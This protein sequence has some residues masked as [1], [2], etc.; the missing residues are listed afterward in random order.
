MTA[1]LDIVEKR[2]AKFN[3]ILGFAIPILLLALLSPVL[4]AAFNGAVAAMGIAVLYILSVTVIPVLNTK[5]ANWKYAELVKEA[6]EN[7]M[8]TLYYRLEQKEAAMKIIRAGVISSNAAWVTFIT[9]GQKALEACRTELEAE[10]WKTRIQAAKDK[11]DHNLHELS[12]REEGMKEYDYTVKRSEI[13]WSAVVAE[14]AANNGKDLFEGTPMDRLMERTSLR[15]IENNLNES[16]ARMQIETI[17]MSK[18]TKVNFSTKLPVAE[19][20]S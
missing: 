5:L 8:P 17:G 10:N 9:A 1:V 18:P 7:P 15:S 16:L 6:N 4:V 11:I 3:S 12:I 14:R 19:R 2:K 13:E 20:V